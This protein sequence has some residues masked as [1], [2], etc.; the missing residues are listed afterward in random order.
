[1][2]THLPKVGPTDA[3]TG[4]Q[5]GGLEVKDEC[6]AGCTGLER[7]TKGDGVVH[8]VDNNSWTETPGRRTIS[9]HH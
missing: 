8:R 1:M 6:V 2:K 4:C 9:Y 5:R 3:S 7:L